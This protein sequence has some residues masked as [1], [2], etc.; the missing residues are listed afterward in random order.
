MI[1]FTLNAEDTDAWRV[2]SQEWLSAKA[3]QCFGGDGGK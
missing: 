1:D 2:S 3:A